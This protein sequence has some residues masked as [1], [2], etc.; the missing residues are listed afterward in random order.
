MSGYLDHSLTPSKSD[1]KTTPRWLDIK[2]YRLRMGLIM[3]AADLL[4]FSVSAL[5]L[6]LL[7]LWLDLFK[8]QWSD[9]KYGVIVV[10]CIIIYAQTK[11]YP[12]IGLNPAEEIRLVVTSTT[13][14]FLLGMFVF[15]AV[16][17]NIWHPNYLAL[18]PFGFAS[19]ALVLAMRWGLRI[20][21][22]QHNIWGAPVV[23]IGSGSGANQLAHYIM[24]RRRLGFIPAYVVTDIAS[25]PDVTV[26]IRTIHP[27]LLLTC[28]ADFFS[29]RQIYTVLVDTSAVQSD[30]YMP[31]ITRLAE[32]FPRTVFIS[33]IQGFKSAAVSVHDLEGIIGV[34]YKQNVLNPL[35]VFIKR[36]MDIV[37]AL[38]LILLTA[39]LWAL[40]LLLIRL[41]S[42]GPIF[43]TQARVGRNRRDPANAERLH[44]HVRKIRIYKL[45]TMIVN[46]DE[47]LAEYLGAHPQARAEWD[48]T[49][50]LKD[51]PRIT[52][53]G[54]WLR[55]FSI[56]E[57]PQLFNVLKGE[58]SLVGPRPMML[59]QIPQYGSKIDT[60]YS[61]NPGLTGLWQVSGR[62]NTTFEERAAFDE[63]YVHNWSVWLDIYILLRTV[64]V[65]ISRDGAY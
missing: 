54:K 25:E 6:F 19:V 8:F 50:K 51:D 39:P 30:W 56:D 58:M 59:D 5:L 47:K 17:D 52:R 62:N 3:L 64:W 60:Y 65:V 9:I 4:G 34:E 27:D 23:V 7:N 28:P 21:S 40:T 16:S 2:R 33:S 15:M 31:V 35:D 44:G 55:K 61:V 22:V 45:R 24:D 46:A 57:L 41:D 20:L 26:P 63:Y 37:L 18:L 53:V 43:Y 48:R 32:L 38:L 49:Q 42:P 29:S 14:A 13:L 10:T 11:L 12:G 1:P 36:S